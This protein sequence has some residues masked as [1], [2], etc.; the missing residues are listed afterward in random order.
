MLLPYSGVW[1][2]IGALR[3]SE[4]GPSNTRTRTSSKV[5]PG[6]ADLCFLV[7]E[8]VSLVLGRLDDEGIAI[9]EGGVVTLR[10]GA[11]GP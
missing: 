3:P 4:T 7:K 11:R 10:T 1:G 2:P 8:D 6:S 9:L 5:V